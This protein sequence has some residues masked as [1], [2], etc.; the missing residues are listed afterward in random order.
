MYNDYCDSEVEDGDDD[1]ARRYRRQINDYNR[2]KLAIRVSK[3]LDYLFHES[4]Y[5]PKFRKVSTILKCR[6]YFL[7]LSSGLISRVIPPLLM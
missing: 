5:D 7:G 1:F 6:L 2:T 4:R 3:T